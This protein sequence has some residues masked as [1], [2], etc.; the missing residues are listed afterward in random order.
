MPWMLALAAALGAGAFL[1]D[2][3]DRLGKDAGVFPPDSQANSPQPAGTIGGNVDK[4]GT[5]AS[6]GLLLVSAAFA[7]SL[8]K[9]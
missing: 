3:A 2:R 5:A 8:V 4:I 6:T 9:R 7:Y 1:I